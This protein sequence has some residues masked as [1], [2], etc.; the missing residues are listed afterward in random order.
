MRSLLNRGVRFKFTLQNGDGGDCRAVAICIPALADQR[1]HRGSGGATGYRCSDR[2]ALCRGR[3]GRWG[4][5]YPLYGNGGYDVQHYRLKIA[6]DPGSDRLAGVATISARTTEG[7][8]RFNLDLQG[9]KVRSVVVDGAGAR[10]SRSDDHELIVTPQR[11][12]A[13]GQRFTT[14]V[15]YDGV[16]RTQTIPGFDIESGFIHTDD[17]ALIAGEPEVAANW[18]PV[19]DHPLDKASYTFEVTVP[20]GLQVIANGRLVGHRTKAGNTTWTWEVREPMASYLATASVGH[21]A[22]HSYQAGGLRFYDAVDPDLYS[23][24]VDPQAPGSPTFGDVVDESFSHQRR[25]LTF[26]LGRFGRY[27]FSTAGGSVDDYDGLFFALENQTRTVY[28]KYFFSDPLSGDFVIVHENAH[29]WYGDSVSVA[30]WKDIWLNEGSRRTRSGCGAKTEGSAPPK[31]TST[32]S[33]TTSSPR[34]T[35]SGRSSWRTRG[36]ST[37]SMTRFIS[38]AR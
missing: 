3:G 1:T 10:W 21:Y 17:G 7:L 31:R 20:A 8:Y 19:N 27:P 16:P 18:Y 25:I 6:Y 30:R 2:A 32:S 15:R 22:L 11:P 29:Q 23:E 12:L 5:Y 37:F 34:T 9:L 4:P 24:S 35:R 26:L 36:W 13:K 38:G 33:T 28:S 14:V